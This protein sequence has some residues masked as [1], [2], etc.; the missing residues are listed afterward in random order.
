[1]KR[2]II[3]AAT[4]GLIVATPG[5]A[6]GRIKPGQFKLDA[7]LGYILVRVGPTQGKKLKSANLYFWRYDVARGDVRFA[8]KKDANPVA[9]GEDQ[10]AFVGDRPFVPGATSSAYLVSVTPGDWVI[11]G[12]DTTAFAMGSYRFA[13]KPG[14]VTD[15]G[16]V[17]IYRDDGN[18]D[19]PALKRHP[20][21]GD[22]VA[23]RA[24]LVGEQIMVSSAPS[25]EAPMSGLN[26]APIVRASL[27]PDARFTNRGG[28][29]PG[30]VAGLLINRAAGLDDPKSGDGAAMVAMVAMVKVAK[31]DT[32][33]KTKPVVDDKPKG[34]QAGATTKPA[35]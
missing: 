3:A 22:I 6:A 29:R 12:T 23:D 30:Y 17:S 27:V 16:T 11:H 32:E 34:D 14:E 4:L 10:S 5:N 25:G 8:K 20:V 21:S 13:V 7:K 2:A 24:Y 35:T 33:L 28:T 18:S 19:E 9:K 26:G 31:D 15:I 1:M